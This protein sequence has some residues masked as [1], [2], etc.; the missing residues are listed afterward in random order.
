MPD[1]G[2]DPLYREIDG[3]TKQ[4]TRDE[5]QERI[6]DF[7][8]EQHRLAG[9][10]DTPCIWHP[11]VPDDPQ[12]VR[13]FVDADGRIWARDGKVFRNGMVTRRWY[14]LFTTG[15]PLVSLPDQQQCPECGASYDWLRWHDCPEVPGE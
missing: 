6:V 13:A 9:G 10:D 15:A 11:T 8:A 3:V 4:V 5:W 12:W 7:A 1:Y 14:D 2:A